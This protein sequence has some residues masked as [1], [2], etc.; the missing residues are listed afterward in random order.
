[1]GYQSRLTQRKWKIGCVWSKPTILTRNPKFETQNSLPPRRAQRYTTTQIASQIAS[2]IVSQIASQIASQT[3]ELQAL[4]Q[5]HA[6]ASKREQKQ[7]IAPLEILEIIEEEEGG[8]GGRRRE[9][10]G[11]ASKQ[12]QAKASKSITFRIL[13]ILGSTPCV[14][15]RM[16]G[17]MSDL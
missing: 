1:M 2:Q 4:E 13:H 3:L 10:E 5:K 7:A 14:Y 11:G 16:L 17:L 8:R 6:K 12:K 15:I 9:E